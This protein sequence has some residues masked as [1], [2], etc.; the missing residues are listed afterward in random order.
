MPYAP[1]SCGGGFI[2]S[3]ARI[4]TKEKPH[5]DPSTRNKLGAS[6]SSS[7]LFRESLAARRH[8]SRDFLMS[9]GCPELR[10]QNLGADISLF[11]VAG[12]QPFVLIPHCPSVNAFFFQ[13]FWVCHAGLFPPR[14]SGLGCDETA[15]YSSSCCWAFIFPDWRCPEFALSVD[16]ELHQNLFVSP[17]S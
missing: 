8:F 14:P 11:F 13:H 6:S 2:P 12:F 15:L 10:T 9:G 5:G 17:G 16:S 4:H 3:P 1:N 7:P